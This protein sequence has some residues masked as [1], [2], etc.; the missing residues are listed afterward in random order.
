MNNRIYSLMIAIIIII[1]LNSCFPSKSMMA[2]S[3]YNTESYWTKI[4]SYT[5]YPTFTSRPAITVE[6]MSIK[7][8]TETKTP[9]PTPTDIPNDIWFTNGPI[10]S[11]ELMVDALAIDPQNPSIVY[12]GGYPKG[13]FKSINGGVDWQIANTGMTDAWVQAFLIDP[14]TSTTIFAGTFEGIYESRTSGDKWWKVIDGDTT[15]MVIDPKASNT[16][17]AGIYSKIYK[18]SNS[19]KTWNQLSKNFPNNFT[20]NSLAIDQNSTTTIY[21]GCSQYWGSFNSDGLIL[22]S[23]DGGEEWHKLSS[24]IRGDNSISLVLDPQHT[25]TIYAGMF[26]GVIKSINSGKDWVFMNEGLTNLS[27]E[28]IVIDPIKPNILYVGTQ[29]GGI[30]KSINGGL[31]WRSFNKG[32]PPRE[33]IY[34]L[35]IDP[36]NPNILYAGSD[37]G[38]YIIHQS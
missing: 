18:S 13:L 16:M 21:A 36:I 32:L 2:T 3:L 22:Q 26:G 14:S 1:F 11:Y 37:E 33:E 12:S 17:Y 28:A 29:G 35:A 10:L 34:S 8:L 23:T 30:F 25:K 4:P 5:Y 19:G 6:V 9:L 7:V 24:I 15:A 27:V 31:S 38:I 20:I